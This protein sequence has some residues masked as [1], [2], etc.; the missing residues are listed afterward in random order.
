[1]K[2]LFASL[3]RL[4]LLAVFVMLIQGCFKD[5]VENEYHYRVFTPIFQTKQEVLDNV[6]LSVPV[7][8]EAPGKIYIKDNYLLVTEN[9]KGIHVF[10]NSNP[11]N[12]KNIGF[13]H[14]PS[15]VDM[16]IKNN[17]LYADMYT[18]LITIDISSPQNAKLKTIV[19]NVFQDKGWIVTKE[20]VIAGWEKRDTVV[21]SKKDAVPKDDERWEPIWLDSW[22]YGYTLNSSATVPSSYGT[23]G[24][25]AR[26]TALSNRLYTVGNNNLGVF[27]ITDDLNPAFVTRKELGWGIETIFPFKGNLFIGSQTGVRIFSITDLDNPK[28]LG[29]FAHVRKCDPVVANDVNAFATLRAGAGCGGNASELTVL[30]IQNLTNPKLV[31]SY[32][33]DNPYGLGL[34]GTTLFICDGI[35]GLKVYNV[36]DVNN[37]KLLKTI[38]DIEPFD[39][40]LKSGLAIVVG[41]KAIYQY[42]YKD[43]SNIKLLSTTKLNK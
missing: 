28:E 15:N 20:R 1:M 6:K 10:D 14:I 12:P 37:I 31:K 39:V 30:D 8:P 24:S 41:K 7:E 23:G 34:D 17:T 13:I 42:D 29:S 22:G 36:A 21:Y 35:A 26:F 2:K 25:M 5:T 9:F 33:L 16:A 40:I 3:A 27:N 4:S 38:K 11:S 32:P 19:P 43:L 18:D